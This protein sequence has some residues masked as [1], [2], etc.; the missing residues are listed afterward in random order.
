MNDIVRI[1][2][3]LMGTTF[4]PKEIS[5]LTRITPD[6][7]LMQGE[8]NKEQ[9]LP[10]QSIWSKMSSTQSDEVSEHWKNLGIIL[11]GSRDILKKIAKTGKATLSI[12]I[13]SRDRIP[14]IR[15]PP[16]MS[17]FAGFVGAVIDVDH[18]QY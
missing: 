16:E 15:I 3:Q 9:N 6:V 12:V 8:R 13:T 18:I 4:S 17:E 11:Y 2:F 5:K 10:R 1:D 7:E 14:S